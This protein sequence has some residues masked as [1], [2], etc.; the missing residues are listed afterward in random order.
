MEQKSISLPEKIE[1]ELS[2]ESE[3][4]EISEGEIVRT[5]LIKHLE[6]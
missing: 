5:A 1:E 6:V 2:R 4:L 3:R